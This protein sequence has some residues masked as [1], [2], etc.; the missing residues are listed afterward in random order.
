MAAVVVERQIDCKSSVAELWRVLTDTSY[1]NRLT[2]E[3]PR[4]IS[5]ME[6]SDGA[7]FRVKTRAGGFSVE[8]EEWPFEW[9]HQQRFRVFRKFSAGPVSSVDTILTFAGKDDGGARIGIKLELIPKI[10]W[11]AWMV[12]FGTRRAADA[13]A[14]SVR[15]VDE[16]LARRAPL[17]VP[18]R[19]KPPD[20][21]SGLE[22]ALR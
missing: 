17:P 10:T 3:A 15:A 16:A 18:T 5:A 12:R 19:A 20:R 7:R 6:G 8:W 9:V 4:Q 22:R 1:L 11:L 13:L 21:L 2:G 14:L